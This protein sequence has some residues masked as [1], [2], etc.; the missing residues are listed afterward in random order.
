MVI[1]RL[2]AAGMS[3]QAVAGT[4]DSPRA[5]S[6]V[7][8]VT[9]ELDDTIRE[10]RNAIFELGLPDVEQSLSAHIS[11]IIEDRSRHLGF[12]PTLRVSG[13]LDT[14]PEHLGEQLVA[15]LVEALSNVARHADATL[16]DVD[17]V[18]GDGTLRLVVRDN[19]VGISGTPKPMG[20]VSNMMW[21][22]AELGGTCAVA[23]AEPTGTELTWFVPV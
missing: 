22:A 4:L 16:A 3:L 6:R 12:T 11:A 9:D 17:I 8:K 2:F 20:G 18:V 5:T 19:G 13:D 21:R 10:L 7:L 15:T 1:Q 23:P 14:V